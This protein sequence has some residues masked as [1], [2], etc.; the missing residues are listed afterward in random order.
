MAKLLIPFV[1]AGYPTKARSLDLL[2][3][4][5]A[6]GADR[7]ELGLPFSDPLADG[8]VIQATS[9]AA[10]ENGTTMLDAFDLAAKFRERPLIFMGYYNPILQFILPR[11]FS[12]CQRTGVSA[13]IIPDL[14]PEESSDARAAAAMADVPLIFLCSPTATDARVRLIDRVSQDFI[15]LV[16]IKGVTGAGHSGDVT[17]FV[18]RVRRL[19]KR[20]LCVGF[21]IATPAHAAA[22]ARVADGVIVGSALLR[23]VQQGGSSRAVERFVASLRR[24]IDAE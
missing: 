23:I 2:K 20:P 4:C 12:R 10:L 17:A 16:S 22:V 21:G 14:P 15:Y 11:F 6:G 1:T 7:I 13:V 3:A 24:A 5:A 8:P 19:S 9:H 18:R